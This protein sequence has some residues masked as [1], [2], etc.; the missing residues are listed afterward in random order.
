[1]L[2]D[3]NVEIRLPRNS[4]PASNPTTA[5]FYELVVVT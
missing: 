4:G 2:S 5:C 1:M 3:I